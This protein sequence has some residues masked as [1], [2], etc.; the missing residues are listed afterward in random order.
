MKITETDS[1][2]SKAEGSCLAILLKKNTPSRLISTELL[3][4]S[5]QLSVRTS[6]AA[7]STNKI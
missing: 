4:K 7:A 5:E 1:F 6:V 2:F 3:Q